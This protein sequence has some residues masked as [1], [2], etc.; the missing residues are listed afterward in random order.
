[1]PVVI[2][3]TKF[4]KKREIVETAEFKETQT[5]YL[6]FLAETF[7]VAWTTFLHRLIHKEFTNVAKLSADG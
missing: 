5:D 7:H 4:F 1:M 3:R 2:I 6:V